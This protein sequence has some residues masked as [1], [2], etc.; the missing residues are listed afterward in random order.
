MNAREPRVRDALS[1]LGRAVVRRAG[2]VP[3]TLP[4]TYDA[5]PLRRLGPALRRPPPPLD[6]LSDAALDAAAEEAM[7]AAGLD[8]GVRGGGLDALAGLPLT[9]D[10]LEAVLDE[11][12][13][14][15]LN[16]DGGDIQLVDIVDDDVHVRLVGACSSCP[17][18]IMTMKMG[19]ERLLQDEFP[20]M[21]ALINVDGGMH[22]VPD[23]GMWLG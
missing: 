3:A 7:R 21:G 15:A 12:V 19:V 14:P 6:A 18:S 9:R 1:R 10:N 11:M 23:T 22:A 2:W 5:A 16:A 20:T 8:T 17:S 13:R 4:D